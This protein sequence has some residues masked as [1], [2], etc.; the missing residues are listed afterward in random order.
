MRALELRDEFDALMIKERSQIHMINI[1]PF[2]TCL[3]I[4]HRKTV[5]PLAVRYLF[6]LRAEFCKH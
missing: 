3:K 2:I 5:R 4:P 6:V 1:S